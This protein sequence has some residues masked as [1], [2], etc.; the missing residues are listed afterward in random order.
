VPRVTK[1]VKLPEELARRLEEQ[2][3]EEGCSDSDLIR[4]GIVRVLEDRGGL[5]MGRLI[6]GDIGVGSG[7]PDLSDGRRHLGGYGR[8]R[9]C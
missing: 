1:S 3:R 5:E 7:P 8:S 2:A 6:G 4:E 9:H